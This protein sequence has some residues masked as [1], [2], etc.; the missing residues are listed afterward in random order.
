MPDVQS[1]TI[2]QAL[3]TVID[4]SQQFYID[5]SWVDP[6]STDTLDVID[7]ATEKPI[8]TIAVGGQ[9]DVD[10]AVSAARR[11]FESFSQTTGTS[12]SPSWRR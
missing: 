6:R 4:H 7:P 1:P 12:G 3:A 10:A 2:D 5:G 9:P 11:A 8:A